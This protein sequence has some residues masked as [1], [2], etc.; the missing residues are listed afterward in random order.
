MSA[1]V[2]S[3]SA[4]FRMLRR[5]LA[6]FGSLALTAFL[7]GSGCSDQARTGTGR[8]GAGSSG[9]NAGG[10]GGGSTTTGAG[11]GLAVA[12]TGGSGGGVTG[13]AGGTAGAENAGAGGTGGASGGSGGSDGSGAAGGSGA[14]AGDGAGGGSTG[15]GSGVA[16]CPADATFCSSFDTNA[17]PDGAIYNRNGAPAEFTTDFAI[18]TETYFSGPGA[19]RVKTTTQE[20]SSA[21]KMLAV[22][23]PGASFWV[24]VY[25][26][27]D[28]ELGQGTISM[29]EHNRFVIAA[30]GAETNTTVALEIA[31]DCG[32]ALNSHDAVYRPEGEGTCD[33]PLRLPPNQWYCLEASFNGTTGDTQVYIDGELVIDAM[34][35]PSGTGAFTHLKFGVDHL[36]PIERQVWYDD[37][38]VGPTRAGCL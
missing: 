18:D 24:R 4:F 6:C 21:Y 33:A 16:P 34:A 29:S 27:A 3:F 9:G 7:A 10:T 14:S 38:A 15:G 32:I 26:R 25:I 17:L 12:G 20:A 23:A 19:L 1:L 36:H 8:S 35:W 5:P 22:P 11:G 31:E 37:V 13:G 28:A 2:D 30:D